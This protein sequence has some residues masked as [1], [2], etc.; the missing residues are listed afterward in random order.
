ML[1]GLISIALGASL[2]AG[3]KL[4]DPCVTPLKVSGRCVPT[5]ECDYATRILENPIV[6][7]AQHR[8][9]RDSV[10]GQIP[11]KPRKIPLICCPNQLNPVTCGSISTASRIVGG[12]PTELEDHPWNAVILY[13]RRGKA[14]PNCGA[15]LISQRYVLTAAHC[16]VGLSSK[17]KLYQIRLSEWDTSSQS[18]CTEV[19]EE[20]ICRQNFEIEQV[21]P[22]PGYST[23]N[24]KVVNDIALIR[25]STDVEFTKFAKPICLP[26]DQEIGERPIEGE[27]LTVIGRGLTENQNSSNFLRSVELMG[28]SHEQCNKNLA[29]INVALEETQLCV[30]GEEGKDSCKGDSGGPLMR[31]VN[32]IWFQVGV[33]S[34]GFKFCGTE[35]VPGIYTNVVKYLDWIKE[36]VGDK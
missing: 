1:V 24:N 21:I 29:R 2:V 13:E 26:L 32:G 18:N 33:V 4:N 27:H 12:E 28:Q 6:T 16:V 19:E 17:Q 7:K 3:L 23:R 11:G 14:I 25:L 30:G 31:F 8:L 36:V 35:G 10:C 22:H 9:L 34:Y 20:E 15:S 5:R